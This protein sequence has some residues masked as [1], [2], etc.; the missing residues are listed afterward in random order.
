MV[1]PLSRAAVHQRLCAP[2]HTGLATGRLEWI[3]GW[4][5]VGDFWI[6]RPLQH[7]FAMLVQSK[8]NGV[9]GV[10][11]MMPRMGLAI[12]TWPLRVRVVLKETTFNA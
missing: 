7:H 3:F 5:R 9:L 8:V 2:S 12:V 10:K 1:F 6:D 11:P 4:L